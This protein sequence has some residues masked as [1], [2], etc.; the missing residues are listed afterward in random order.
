MAGCG[1]LRRRG[2]EPLGVRRIAFIV[3][4]GLIIA[5]FVVMESIVA[6]LRG[7]WA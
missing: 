7:W 4:V 5:W 3:G 1:G 2:P 6:F